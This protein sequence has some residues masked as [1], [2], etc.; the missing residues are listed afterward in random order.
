[1]KTLV[2][3]F[4]RTGTTKKAAVAIAN[5]LQ[6]DIEEIKE[7][8]TRAGIRGWLTAGRD[9][10][11]GSLTRI[12]DIGR[13]ISAYDIIIIGG[14]IWAW[15]VCPPVRTFLVQ[16]MDQIKNAAFFC[17]EGGSGSEKAFYSMEKAAGKVPLATLVLKSAEV[18]S[19]QYPEKVSAF[20]DKIRTSR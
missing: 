7:N 19:G 17:T 12:K 10:S 14:P 18:K 2:L 16:F 8:K 3:Y 13:D 6:C 20:V 15:N 1:M 4:S 5:A 9:A 11:R